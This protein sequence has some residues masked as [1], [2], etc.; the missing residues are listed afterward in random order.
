MLAVKAR[1]DGRR[2][3]LTEVPLCF[4]GTVIVVFTNQV[5]G[6]ERDE[7]NDFSLQDLARIYGPDVPDYSKAVVRET[8][9]D[10]EP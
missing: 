9:A 5:A 7:C 1:F 6:R 10:Y 3:V 4:T 8:N 2:I